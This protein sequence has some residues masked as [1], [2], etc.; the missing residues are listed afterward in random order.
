MECHVLFDYF[1]PENLRETPFIIWVSR[2][3]H[4]HPP[5]PPS[6]IPDVHRRSLVALLGVIKDPT[7]TFRKYLLY[8]LLIVAKY[9]VQSGKLQVSPHLR[10]WC[11]SQGQQT[12]SDV[13]KGFANPATLRWIIRKRHLMD[14]P[15]GGAKAK[16]YHEYMMNH[17]GR[18]DAV[19]FTKSFIIDMLIFNK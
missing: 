2:G 12:L 16:V 11:Q 1:E 7:L 15:I 3:T 17:K 9:F 5:P 6:K 18:S 19:S 8:I 13:S 14:W 10:E 4:T